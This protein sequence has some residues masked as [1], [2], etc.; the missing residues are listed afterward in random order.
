MKER[1]FA[2]IQSRN[3][4]WR[5]S[6]SADVWQILKYCIFLFLYLFSPCSLRTIFTFLCKNISLQPWLILICFLPHRSRSLVSFLSLGHSV[7]FSLHCCVGVWGTLV[8]SAAERKVPRWLRGRPR[9]YVIMP[10]THTELCWWQ[11]FMEDWTQGYS[12]GII[13]VKTNPFVNLVIGLLDLWLRGWGKL[14]G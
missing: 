12:C 8:T 14:G 10:L 9:V 7:F 2:Y 6:E 3:Q 5:R 11:W 13:K 4:S 1:R